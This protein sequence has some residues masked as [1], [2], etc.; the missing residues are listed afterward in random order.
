MRRANVV[1]TTALPADGRMQRP[2][3]IAVKYNYRFPLI[4]D[5]YA[6]QVGRDSRVTRQEQPTDGEH[7]LPYLLCILFDPARPRIV[8]PMLDRLPI[9]AAPGFVKEHRFGSGSALIECEDV[10]HGG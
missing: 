3:S 9:Q 5:A 1:A 7:I 8:L 6:P 4:G 10:G 2:A